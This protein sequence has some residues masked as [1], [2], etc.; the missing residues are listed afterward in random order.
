ML[1][2]DVFY[3]KKR[4]ERSERFAQH[5]NATRGKYLQVFEYC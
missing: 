2:R 3:E 1:F 5:Q 4:S